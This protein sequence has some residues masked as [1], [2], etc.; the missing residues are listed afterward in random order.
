[1]KR[2]ANDDVSSAVSN[3]SSSA[4]RP[5]NRRRRASR[6]RSPS[7][8][9]ACQRA[10]QDGIPLDAGGQ[11]AEDAAARLAEAAGAE[12]VGHGGGRVADEQRG[13]EGER[14]VLDA[15]AGGPL[16]GRRCEG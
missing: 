16:V 7:M 9:L 5:T 14:Q 1:M 11:R 15:A 2:T 6:R 3:S 10:L 12:G 8:G 13:L 4:A